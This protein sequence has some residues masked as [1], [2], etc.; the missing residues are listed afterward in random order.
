MVSFLEATTPDTPDLC[1]RAAI[2]GDTRAALWWAT[3]A[4]CASYKTQAK[5][6]TDKGCEPASAGGGGGRGS[7]CLGERA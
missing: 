2:M 3:T 1:V 4:T 5:C 7:A 6:S